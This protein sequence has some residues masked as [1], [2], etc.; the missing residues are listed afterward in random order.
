MADANVLYA[1]Q[2]SENIMQLAQ[3]K[4][5]K[6]LG[7]VF[8]KP[9]V[10][11]KTFFQDQIGQW[12]MKV[13]AGRNASTPASDPNLAR[14]MAIMVDYH[15]NVL[16][17]RADELKVISD[18]KSA[19]TIAAGQAIGRKIDDVIIAA[20]GGT[21]YT[22]ETGGTTQALPTAQKIAN[23]SAGLSLTKVTQAKRILDENDVDENDRFFV[24]SPQGLEDL[25]NV[26]QATS[27]DYAAVKALVRGEIETWMGFT[28][29]KSTRL[30]LS[31]TIRSCFAFQKNAAV[32]GMAAM[33]FV[34]TDERADLS[35][36]WQVYYELNLGA[37]RLEEDGVVQVD[38]VES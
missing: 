26:Q 4:Y 38:I 24:T 19:Y 7:A 1:Q 22:G 17:D 3:Q 27:A 30:G 25:L 2:Y 28:W 23:G 37:T 18:P 35:Y 12:S 29:I 34:R 8:Q 13:R 9:N 15:D 10:K 21:A 16:L 33:P 31:S 14:R 36:S 11:G 32:L 5:A 6:L 20:L